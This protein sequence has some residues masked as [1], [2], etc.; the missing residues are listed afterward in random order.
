MRLCCPRG[1]V[2]SLS[3]EHGRGQKNN[4]LGSSILWHVPFVT[5]GHAPEPEQGLT[6]CL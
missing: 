5:S 3:P 6:T 4:I 2:L 1:W